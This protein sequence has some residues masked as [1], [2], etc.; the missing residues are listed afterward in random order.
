MLPAFGATSLTIKNSC[1]EQRHQQY[2][3]KTELASPSPPLLKEEQ[4]AS[5]KVARWKQ[6]STAKWTAERQLGVCRPHRGP[7]SDGSSLGCW[8]FFMQ[9]WKGMC[10]AS[11]APISGKDIFNLKTI[12]RHS[13]SKPIQW[14]F[15][16]ISQCYLKVHQQHSLGTPT[17]PSVP[18]LSTLVLVSVAVAQASCKCFMKGST[19]P[20]Q[21]GSQ[22]SSA[23]CQ[24]LQPRTRRSLRHLCTGLKAENEKSHPSCRFW[25]KPKS[26]CT[27]SCE[28]YQLPGFTWGSLFCAVSYGFRIR[29][30]CPPLPCVSDNCLQ[31]E[32]FLLF[33][34]RRD[35]L[36]FLLLRWGYG[37]TH[38]F[39]WCI[40]LPLLLYS[41]RHRS[42]WPSAFPSRPLLAVASLLGLLIP[43]VPQPKILQGLPIKRMPYK[44]LRIQ[45]RSRAWP[46]RQIWRQ[47]VGLALLAPH[48]RA[49]APHWVRLRITHPMVA[50]RGWE[51]WILPAQSP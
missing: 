38:H 32:G 13:H 33:A 10:S 19:E 40:L 24:P 18:Q 44:S 14:W 51:S 36:L 7:C 9:V 4:Q 35:L 42:P 49:P 29:L 23:A 48:R 39:Y 34:L 43:R 21:A 26:L 22:P 2:H 41:T 1:S 12:R 47:R 37:H 45:I 50:S 11:G 16:W 15:P 3:A 25:S 6:L 5:M 8:L 20:S 46:G 31:M 17:L 27:V 30:P 28:I